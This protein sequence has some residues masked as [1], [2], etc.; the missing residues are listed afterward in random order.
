[1]VTSTQRAKCLNFENFR[2]R[3]NFK[4]HIRLY[5]PK[6]LPLQ[7]EE[8]DQKQEKYQDSVGIIKNYV[9]NFLNDLKPPLTC[10]YYAT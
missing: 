10:Q 6:I 1:M 2:C 5:I 9:L 8:S 4:S 3:T 7:S